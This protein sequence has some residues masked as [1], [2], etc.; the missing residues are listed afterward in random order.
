M[1]DPKGFIDFSLASR[2]TMSIAVCLAMAA[3]IPCAEA[4]ILSLTRVILLTSHVHLL[5]NISSAVL[6]IASSTQQLGNGAWKQ[7]TWSSSLL[8]GRAFW[9]P[10][11]SVAFFIALTIGGGPQIRIFMSAAGGGSFS[12]IMSGV[13]KPT[14][15]VQPV[16][17]LFRT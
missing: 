4:G 7:K 9:Y 11:L 13:T 1:G 10:R 14:P 8:T 16:G 2:S 12:L 15:P 17:G 5:R 3:N 6:F